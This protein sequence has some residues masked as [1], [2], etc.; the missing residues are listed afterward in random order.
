[1][2]NLNLSLFAWKKKI[3]KREISALLQHCKKHH[4]RRIRI[5]Q[6]LTWD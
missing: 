4:W 2:H 6:K 3:S 1:L 5:P